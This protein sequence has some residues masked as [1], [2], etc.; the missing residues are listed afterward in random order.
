MTLDTK[1]DYKLIKS[2]YDNLY[3][4][5]HDFYLCEMIELLERKP[6]LAL[7][8]ASIEQKKLI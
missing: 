2:I 8:N 6:E 7:I 5:S 3:H 4:G 1:E